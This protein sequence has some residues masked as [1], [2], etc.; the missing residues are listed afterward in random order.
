MKRILLSVLA[1]GATSIVLLSGTD[2]FLADSEVSANNTFE[3][4][5][6]DLKIDSTAHYN[7]MVCDPTTHTWQLENPQ[8][9]PPPFQFPLP[10]SPCSGSWILTDLTQEKFFDFS[11]LKPGDMGENTIS[12]HVVD[13]SAWACM[14]FSNFQNNDPN[15]T[16]PELFVDQSEGSGEGELAQS[17]S[18]FAWRDDGDNLFEPTANPPEIPLLNPPIQ[19]ADQILNQSIITLADTT[20]VSGPIIGGPVD[21]EAS[22]QYLGWQWCL[23]TIDV[24]LQTGE[25]SCD[26]SALGNEVQ[27]D[28]IISDLTFRIEQAGNNLDFVCQSNQ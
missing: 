21:D 11:D 18:M 2:A 4:G 5:G 23:G 26:G 9:S 25:T 16:E 22:T 7:G 28:Q 12:L 8:T 1:V 17:L 15:L 19:T 20:T 3:A 24:N 14:E 10:N 27:T 6:I 13:N